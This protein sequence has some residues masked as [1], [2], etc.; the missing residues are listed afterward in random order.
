MK[1]P[2]KSFQALTSGLKNPATWFIEAL[3]GGKSKTGVT[4]NA[5]TALGLPAVIY[6]VNKISGHMAQLPIEVY[7]EDEGLERVYRHKS[8]AWQL[9][10][11]KPNDLMSPF[12]LREVMMI[13][14]LITGNGRAYIERNSIGEPIGLIPIQPQSCRTVFDGK[15]KWHL[16]APVSGE[17]Q[18]IMSDRLRKGEY[19]KVHDYDMLHVMNTSYNGLWGMHIIDIA[20]DVFGLGQVGQEASAYAFANNGRPGMILEAPHNTFRTPKDA[21]EFLDNFNEKHAG[22]KNSGRAGLLR[23]GMKAVTLPIDSAAAQVLQQR[24]FQR[25][26]VALLFGLESI[27]GDNSGQTYKSISERNA[28]YINN[29]LS[30]WFCK[31][32][33]EIYDKLNTKSNIIIEFDTTP[34]LQSDPNTL[35]DYSLK[36]QQTSAVTINEIRRMHGLPPVESGDKL[37]H[38]IAMDITKATQPE[39]GDSEGTEEEPSEEPRDGTGTETED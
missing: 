19:Y 32:Q 28:A 22:I 5:S 30:R 24:A 11:R 16:V 33:Q 10:N 14:A 27:I 37:P 31:W 36:M 1:L 9:L 6:A 34:L 38:E 2:G 15:D 18:A 20:K 12:T 3:G 4:V 26:E 39:E 7:T 35:A 8:P 25:E 17:P 29:C 21:R 13:H 23:D